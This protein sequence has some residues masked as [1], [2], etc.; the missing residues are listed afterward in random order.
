MN[1][2]LAPSTKALLDA[3][4]SD[5]PG[6][7]AKARVWS[8]VADA[9]GATGGGAAAPN[10]PSHPAGAGGAHL[11]GG[12]TIFGGAVTV[13]LTAFFLSIGGAPRAP[14]AGAVAAAPAPAGSLAPHAEPAKTALPPDPASVPAT[15][16]KLANKL[17][18][19]AVTPA[20]V[21]TAPARTAFA[22]AP[23]TP[24]ATPSPAA[25]A[26]IRVTPRSMEGTAAPGESD[27][28]EREASLVAAARSALLK[29]DPQ[30]A[31]DRIRAARAIPSG[32]LAPEELALEA[33]ALRASGRAGQADSAEA[34]LRSDYPESA[35]AR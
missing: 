22:A 18:G 9:T 23:A 6:A 11:S 17:A 33:Q 8:K 29:G 10:R 28:L 15:E 31:L 30:R 32:V 3:A 7:T 1:G 26:A 4:K 13:G 16:G 35:L 27:A 19:A 24:S 2:R 14:I 21:R 20:Q 25:P 12:L 5:G 34:K